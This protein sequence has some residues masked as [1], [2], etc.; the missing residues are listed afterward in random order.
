MPSTHNFYL[1]LA[2][3]TC[4]EI[5]YALTHSYPSWL[6]QC[7]RIHAGCPQWCDR[8]GPHVLPRRRKNMKPKALTCMSAI[9]VFA[10]LTMAMVVE[11]QDKAADGAISAAHH[12]QQGTF[13]I[14]Q[15]AN[16]TCSGTTCTVTA[17]TAPAAG[18][19]DVFI[20]IASYSA[21]ASNDEIASVNLGG[22]LS[23]APGCLGAATAGSPSC[24]YILP[25]T[26]TGG[27][28]PIT[29][30]LSSSV[31]G[32]DAFFV[33]VHPSANSQNVGLRDQ[34]MLF[35]QPTATATGPNFSDI[36]SADAFVAFWTQLNSGGSVN[37]T[38][39]SAPYSS[40]QYIP[41]TVGFAAATTSTPPTWTAQTDPSVFPL[42]GGLVFGWNVTPCQ[43]IAL[44]PFSVKKRAAVGTAPT[45]ASLVSTQAGWLGGH[46]GLSGTATNGLT[47]QT[48]PTPLPPV[49]GI[50]RACGDGNTYPAAPLPAQSVALVGPSGTG[51]ANVEY[52][53]DANG[54]SAAPP[55]VSAGMWFYTDAPAASGSVDDCMT[56]RGADQDFAAVNCYSVGGQQTIGLE[57]PAGGGTS[58]S[59]VYTPGTWV[60]IQNTFNHSVSHTQEVWD[61]TNGY[62]SPVYTN[63]CPVLAS[64]ND[65]AARVSIGQQAS[66]SGLIPS[67]TH[68]YYYY[69]QISLTGL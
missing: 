63:S 44:N 12:N 14:V 69:P 27:S 3:A 28:A 26:S 57:C 33:E 1:V 49:H 64:A 16:G 65:Y 59:Y 10:A 6:S 54:T 2:N 46:W 66:S 17:G 5:G 45:V 56:I 53:F 22:T 29:I 7:T 21:I 61:S 15:T 4:A 62:S 19:V 55:S 40:N 39:V 41:G 52:Q 51:S 31:A 60:F 35:F 38:S 32:G 24:A 13:T 47:Y 67:G 20:V 42:I 68:Y 11:A 30:N 36:Q 8:N 34:G 18:N 37:L 23:Q 25:M 9:T 58:P 50:G 43:N 48:V